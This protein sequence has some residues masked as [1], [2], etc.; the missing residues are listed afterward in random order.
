V[1]EKITSVF[2]KHPSLTLRVGMKSTACGANR[3]A[4]EA[5]HKDQICQHHRTGIGQSHDADGYRNELLTFNE[6]AREFSRF[7]YFVNSFQVSEATDKD[8]KSRPAG[9]S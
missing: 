2:H 7:T 9:S 3:Q 6:A 4:S 8:Q 1:R 5:T